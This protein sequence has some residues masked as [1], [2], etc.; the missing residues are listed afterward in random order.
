MHGKLSVRR[1]SAQRYNTVV[2]VEEKYKAGIPASV[3]I[4]SST[5]PVT[6]DSPVAAY[7]ELRRFVDRYGGATAQDL[8]LLPSIGIAKAITLYSNVG[9][10]YRRGIFEPWVKD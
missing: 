8:H 10:R 7:N 5:F 4:S 2:A 6:A 1:W 3:S 9:V